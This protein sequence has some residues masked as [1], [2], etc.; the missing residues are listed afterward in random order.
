MATKR[1]PAKSVSKTLWPAR[2]WA[3]PRA[4]AIGNRKKCIEFVIP[5]ACNEQSLSSAC[6]LGPR[7]LVFRL[8]AFLSQRHRREIT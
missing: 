7:D 6:A 1:C 5:R 4:R 8:G 2:L 3:K